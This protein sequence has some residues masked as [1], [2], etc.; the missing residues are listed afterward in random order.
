MKNEFFDICIIEENITAKAG[1]ERAVANLAN[2]LCKYGHQVTI[3]S[4][5][6]EEKGVSHF[7]LD[8]KVKIIHLTLKRSNVLTRY[9]SYIQ[10]YR[11]GKQ[12]INQNEFDFVIG[13]THAI[14]SVITL[15]KKKVQIIGC[16]HFNYGSCSKSS[17]RLRKFFYQKL[18]AVVLLTQ[19]DAKHYAFLSPE[20]VFVIPNSL[21]FSCDEPAELEKKRIIAAG[22]LTYQKGFDMLIQASAIMKQ[23]IPDWKLDIYGDGED[24]DKLENMI[25]NT[26]VEDFVQ[27]HPPTEKIKEEMMNASIFVLSSRFEG[28]ALISIEAQACGVPIV[29]FDCPE[30]PSELITNEKDG[31]L[32]ESG[33]IELLAEKVVSLALDKVKRKAFGYEAYCASKRFDSLVIVEKW[34]KLFTDLG[35]TK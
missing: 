3:I 15:F 7:S 22:R 23:E 34:N 18:N 9:F 16:E 10:L 32:V 28:F 19:N 26:G 17:N 30:G 29:S 6:S 8:N 33:N 14:N 27:I 20:K 35:K 12:I 21:S 13:T 2:S 1:I 4:L 24:K 5:Y 11:R 25:I 31:Y